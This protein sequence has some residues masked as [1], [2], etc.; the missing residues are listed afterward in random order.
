LQVT[1][2]GVDAI[3]KY[4]TSLRGSDDQLFLESGLGAHSTSTSR[5]W[6]SPNWQQMIAMVD[7][8][9]MQTADGTHLP[10]PYV[11]AF[12]EAPEEQVSLAEKQQLLG[13]VTKALHALW[14]CLKPWSVVDPV[15]SMKPLQKALVSIRKRIAPPQG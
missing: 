14:D 7:A 9:M 2:A 15:K 12:W 8:G 6:S 1:P 10:L 13:E 5:N 3:R 4:V 11:K